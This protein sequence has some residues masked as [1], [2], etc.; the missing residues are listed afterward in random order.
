MSVTSPSSTVPGSAPGV[1]VPD[2]ALGAPVYPS[3]DEFVATW[4]HQMDVF[5]A[6]DETLETVPLDPA[7]I[8]VGPLPETPELGQV[9]MFGAPITTSGFVGGITNPDT[10]EVLAVVV[11]GDPDSSVLRL[12][13]GTLLLTTVDP[14]APEAV[15]LG[16]AWQ[17]FANDP[18]GI[19]SDYVVVG[20]VGALMFTLD[21]AEPDD[22]LISVVMA[23]AQ[24]ELAA[25]TLGY[26]M[27][28]A[29]AT[30]VITD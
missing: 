15:A 24:D 28:I 18:A 13:V 9:D 23:P 4:N 2:V 19:L 14:M 1:T 3:V 30:R 8:I 27:T 25:V 26:A 5:S 20:E 12:A 22:P 7:T 17:V 16:D 11:G 29:V 6:L 21:G 10:G